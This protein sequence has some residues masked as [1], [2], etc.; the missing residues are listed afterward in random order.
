VSGRPCFA[1]ERTD[2][3]MVSLTI[4]IPPGSMLPDAPREKIGECPMCPVHLAET[5]AY[6]IR[7]PE[8]AL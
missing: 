4:P 7:L 5:R 1:C 8:R 6:P 2:T 3:V